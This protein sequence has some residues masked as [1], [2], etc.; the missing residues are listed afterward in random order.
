MMSKKEKRAWEVFKVLLGK[1]PKYPT[2]IVEADT[3]LFYM[4]ATEIVNSVDNLEYIYKMNGKI[5]KNVL[6][7]EEI[8]E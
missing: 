5:D 3:I 1:T 4:R 2:N 7:G 8:E 6:E